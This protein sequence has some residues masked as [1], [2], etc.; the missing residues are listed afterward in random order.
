M[1]FEVELLIDG[2]TKDI[3]IA[4]DGRVLEVE[5]Q[6]E[7]GSSPEVVKSGLRAAARSGK[8]AKVES[9]TKN[10][11]LVA[12]EAKVLSDGKHSE[13]QVGPDGKRLGDL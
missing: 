4:S 12:Y 1:E 11:V 9:I 10:G 5:E 2:H 6:V 7:V 8:I 3:S 13:V